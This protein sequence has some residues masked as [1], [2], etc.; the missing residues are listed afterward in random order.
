VYEVLVA[1]D[2]RLSGDGDPARGR[3]VVEADV[4]VRILLQLVALVGRV[5]DDKE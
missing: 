2:L 5:V 3:R 1:A 4:D